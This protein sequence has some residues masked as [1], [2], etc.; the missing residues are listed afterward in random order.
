MVMNRADLSDTSD[1]KVATREA[2][3]ADDHIGNGLWAGVE[4][5]A[6]WFPTA[7]ASGLVVLVFLK[8]ILGVDRD[9]DSLAYHVPFA[10]RRVGLMTNWWLPSAQ[11]GIA[12][13][14]HGFPSWRI[15]CAAGCGGFPAGQRR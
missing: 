2:G 14:Y 12:G 11:G 10:A 3:L 8:A 5:V 7:L 9:W 13:Y 15:C 1:R 4:R 6:R